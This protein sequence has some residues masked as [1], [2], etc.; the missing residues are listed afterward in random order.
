MDKQLKTNSQV[1]TWNKARTKFSDLPHFSKYR[2]KQYDRYHAAARAI[3]AGQ[4][5]EE[6]RNLVAG[7][8]TEIEQSRITLQ[9]GQKLFHGRSDEDLTR[10]KYYP[11]FVSTSLNFVVA[12]NSAYRRSG[13][14]A[15]NGPAIV[16]ALSLMMEVRAIWGHT[17]D[18]PEWEL[19]LPPNLMFEE[20]SR[21]QGR[22]FLFIEANVVN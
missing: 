11:S 18:C 14:K 20:T 13:V 2:K 17:F 10:F 19:L 9:P 16:Y 3:A 12:E 8:R 1:L 22:K 5:T 7:L 21:S 4:V 15:A 6:Q